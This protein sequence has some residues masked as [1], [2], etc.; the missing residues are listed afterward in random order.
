ML[1]FFIASLGL[2]IMFFKNVYSFF[3]QPSISNTMCWNPV[4]FRYLDASRQSFVHFFINQRL[5][6]SSIFIKLLSI[7]R[8][9]IRFTFPCWHPSRT[10]SHVKLL[11]LSRKDANSTLPWEKQFLHVIQERSAK[12]N[13]RSTM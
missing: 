7:L 2:E 8:R 9:K 11:S 13:N 1:L 10:D 12:Q 3:K 5:E 4:K 6:L